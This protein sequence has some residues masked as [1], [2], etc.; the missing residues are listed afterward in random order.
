MIPTNRKHSWHRRRSKRPRIFGRLY[1]L[2]QVR[3]I[4]RR[5]FRFHRRSPNGKHVRRPLY[6]YGD[7]FLYQT[8]QAREGFKDHYI[9]E[10]RNFVEPEVQKTSFK[11]T[12]YGYLITTLLHPVVPATIARLLRQEFLQTL[13]Q[14]ADMEWTGLSTNVLLLL[15][16]L[17]TLETIVQRKRDNASWSYSLTITTAEQQHYKGRLNRR[18]TQ[19]SFGLRASYSTACFYNSRE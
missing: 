13:S 2:K 5:R 12:T 16:Q 3:D 19:T 1:H 18:R 9:G 11:M 10:F 4:K 17:S 14:S 8:E 7:H 6:L 15:V